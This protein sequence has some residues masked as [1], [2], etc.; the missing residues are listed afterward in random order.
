M[1]KIYSFVVF[2]RRVKMIEDQIYV[3]GLQ[4][5]DPFNERTF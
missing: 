4:T 5:I 1:R 2:G 3:T